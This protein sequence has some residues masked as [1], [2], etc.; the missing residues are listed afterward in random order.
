MYASSV[1]LRRHCRALKRLSSS[2]PNKGLSDY[3]PTIPFWEILTAGLLQNSCYALCK[4]EEHDGV[5]ESAGDKEYKMPLY[6]V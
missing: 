4:D 2:A 3:T 5:L 6:V 1:S